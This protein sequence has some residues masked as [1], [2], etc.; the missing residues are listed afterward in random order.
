MMRIQFLWL[1]V[2]MQMKFIFWCDGRF[3]CFVCVDFQRQLCTK[4]IL[5]RIQN[6]KMFVPNR[7]I[8]GGALLV[9]AAIISQCFAFSS[10]NPRKSFIK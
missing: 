5:T 9:L 10:S 2:L 4:L 7:R 8:D 3:F 1:P 6:R